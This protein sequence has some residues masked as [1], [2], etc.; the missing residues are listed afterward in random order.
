MKGASADLGM[1][2]GALDVSDLKWMLLIT[3]D[4]AHTSILAK[5][6]WGIALSA[7]IVSLSRPSCISRYLICSW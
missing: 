1:A 2:Q 5:M 4:Q 7:E 3:V 6:I